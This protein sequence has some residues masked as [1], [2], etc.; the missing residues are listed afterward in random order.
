MENSQEFW[1]KRWQLGAGTDYEPYLQAC[2]NKQDPIIDL[3]K[4]RGIRRV[5]DA[6]C[7]YGAWSLMLA[8]AGFQVEGFDIAPTAVEVTK[9]MLAAYGIDASRYKAASVLDTGYTEPFD[10]VT[11][12]SVLDHMSV[13]DGKKALEELL[14]IV[15]PGGL[16]V[17]SFDALDEEDLELPHQLTGDGSILYTEGSRAGMVFHAYT[18]DELKAWL[19]PAVLSYTNGRGERFFAIERP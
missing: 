18:D 10:A 16:L 6:G 3:F 17:V 8:S 2:C 15:K 4:H 11:A 14:R 9:T 19:G 5:C 13:S 7:G 12:V 1:E